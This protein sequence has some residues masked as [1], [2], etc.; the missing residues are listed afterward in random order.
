MIY[1]S[2]T[3][4]KPKGLVG[5]IRFLILTIP[6]SK[7]AQKAKGILI[8]RSIHVIDINTHYLCGNQK[9]TC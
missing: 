3:G 8:T 6:A 2:V 4:I 9:N 1:V 5:W 7:N